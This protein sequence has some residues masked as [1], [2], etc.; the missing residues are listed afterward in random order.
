MSSNTGYQEVTKIMTHTGKSISRISDTVALGR[1]LTPAK[2][3]ASARQEI[4]VQ[5]QSGNKFASRTR[6]L[7]YGSSNFPAVTEH[8]R[9]VEQVAYLINK[10][11]VDTS[12]ATGKVF[13]PLDHFPATTKS[14]IKEGV[15]FKEAFNQDRVL[16][17]NMVF[18]HKGFIKIAKDKNEPT[19]FISKEQFID[20]GVTMQVLR[21]TPFYKKFLIMKVFKRWWYSSRGSFYK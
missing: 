20:E 17:G 18:T 10:L 7:G 12:L 3:R 5:Q 15:V 1:N 21:D 4:S 14:T 16:P 9:P 6:S 13:I 11:N 2:I 19:E 8:P